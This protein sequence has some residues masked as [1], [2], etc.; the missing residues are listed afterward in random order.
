MIT[1]GF[2]ITL[3]LRTGIPRRWYMRGDGVKRWADNDEPLDGC[4]W[5]SGNEPCSIC[6]RRITALHM[7]GLLQEE[8]RQ[9]SHNAQAH[10]TPRRS[11]AEAWGSGAAPCWAALCSHWHLALWKC[12]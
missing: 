7:C 6:P 9:A 8:L 11:E 10:P 4:T 12:L 1:G 2:G 3:D 5:T